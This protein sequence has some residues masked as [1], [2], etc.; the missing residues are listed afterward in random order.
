M[1]Q[2]G[3]ETTALKRAESDLEQT[4]VPRAGHR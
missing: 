4:E 3:N 1:E 2:R